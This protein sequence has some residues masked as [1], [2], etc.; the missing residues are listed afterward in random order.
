MR[1]CASAAYKKV[2]LLPVRVHLLLLLVQLAAVRHSLAGS[3]KRT[4]C[5]D[6]VLVGLL[7][8]EEAGLVSAE[9]CSASRHARNRRCRSKRSCHWPN[10]SLMC[11][12][13]SPAAAGWLSSLSANRLEAQASSTSCKVAFRG[14]SSGKPIYF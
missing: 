11:S 5:A 9:S 10:G 12:C 14:D 2:L 13:Q 6:C 7:L 4:A 1:Q 3:C 8:A